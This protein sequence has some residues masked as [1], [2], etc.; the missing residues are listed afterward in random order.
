MDD[1]G[2]PILSHALKETYITKIGYVYI[3][4]PGSN[5][6]LRRKVSETAIDVKKVCNEYDK[7]LESMNYKKPRNI[8]NPE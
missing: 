8:Y 1:F 4:Y 5:S 6:M 2:W 7:L 3:A